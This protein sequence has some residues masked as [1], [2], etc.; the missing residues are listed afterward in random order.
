MTLHSSLAAIFMTICYQ[1]FP[2]SKLGINQNHSLIGVLFTLCAQYNTTEVSRLRV[3]VTSLA[4]Y[5]SMSVIV[6]TFMLPVNSLLS[7]TKEKQQQQNKNKHT[8]NI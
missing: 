3:R 2:P 8:L 5:Y 7:I 1:C 4:V 6:Y